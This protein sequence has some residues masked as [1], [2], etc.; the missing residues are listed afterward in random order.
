MFEKAAQKYKMLKLLH[1]LL[2]FNNNCVKIL[3]FH[4]LNLKK[5]RFLYLLQDYVRHVAIL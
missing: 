5:K 1:N 4:L 3:K 2:S